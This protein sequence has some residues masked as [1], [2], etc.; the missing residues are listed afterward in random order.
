MGKLAAQK[1]FNTTGSDTN[2]IKLYYSY[3]KNLAL[4]T[5]RIRLVDSSGVSKNNL[6]DADFVTEYL[7]KN[8]DSATLLEMAKPGEG[9]LIDRMHPLKDNL[10][11]TRVDLGAFENNPKAKKCSLSVGFKDYGSHTVETPF[12]QWYCTDMELYL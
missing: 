8:K 7:I 4:D 1:Q 2:A 5:S 12:G 6:V 10:T 3:L 11:A 9:T